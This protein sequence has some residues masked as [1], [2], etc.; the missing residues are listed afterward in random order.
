MADRR[1][2]TKKIID[3]DSFLDMPLST[4]ALYFHLA[5]RADDDGFLNNAK[6]IMRVIGAAQNDYDLL[7]DK[8][9]II[10]FPDGICVIKHWRMHN[11][12][13][14]DR[15]KPTQYKQEKAM[16]SLKDN[17]AYTL[18]K[19][20]TGVTLDTPCIQHGDVMETEWN[21]NGEHLEAQVRLGKDRVR[22]RIDKDIVGPG[23]P[24]PTPN[25][26]EFSED[27]FEML[28]VEALIHSCLE[29][30][31]KS[32]VPDTPQKKWK[33][34]IEID[35]MKRCD[36]LTEEEIRAALC[37]A[38]HDSFWKDN[39]RSARKFREKFETLYSQSQ[40][41]KNTCGLTDTANR[42]TQFAKEDENDA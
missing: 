2:F 14:G 22:D 39:I 23:G 36:K 5:M 6:K 3:S 42:L 10:Q 16:L 20:G 41:K 12:I 27:S 40:N 30:F 26:K 35:R 18:Q 21:Q 1:M 38:T 17:N 4:Q 19:N 8:R 13:K 31:P 9:F 15:Y 34:A 11:Y 32:R 25:Q 7:V 37:H 24:T 28:C 33:W 29:T